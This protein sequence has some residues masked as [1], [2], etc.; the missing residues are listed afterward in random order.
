[1]AEIDQVM[2]NKNVDFDFESIVECHI[3]SDDSFNRVVA[4]LN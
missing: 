3:K 4:E 2:K 1:M